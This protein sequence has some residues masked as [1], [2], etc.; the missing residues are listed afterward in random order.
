MQ[1]DSFS[2]MCCILDL[3]G[4]KQDLFRHIANNS[5]VYH[6][7]WKEIATAL[8]ATNDGNLALR[9]REKYCHGDTT[10]E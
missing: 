9:I 5:M 1:Y 10:G 8:D 2:R 4:Q 3:D 6:I 7:T